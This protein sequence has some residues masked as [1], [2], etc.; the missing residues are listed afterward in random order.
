MLHSVRSK[1]LNING[2]GLLDA[3][4]IL[5]VTSIAALATLSLSNQT[6]KNLKTFKEK[7]E[8]QSYYDQM[9]AILG[10]TNL[11]T[12]A[13]YQKP[14]NP[15]QS[16]G[17]P[18]P[19][20]IA[21][22][23]TYRVTTPQLTPSGT[24]YQLVP[25]VG[26]VWGNFNVTQVELKAIPGVTNTAN[27][28]HN[29]FVDL[30][31]QLTPNTKLGNGN[32]VFKTFKM[33]ITLDSA[34]RISRCTLSVADAAVC[35]AVDGVWNGTTQTCATGQTRCQELG[36]TWDA[37]KNNCDLGAKGQ[38]QSYGGTWVDSTSGNRLPNTGA[39]T[40]QSCIISPAG[41]CNRLGGT[42]N[43]NTGGCRMNPNGA[44]TSLGGAWQGNY[45]RFAEKQVCETFGGSWEDGARRCNF[46]HGALC[47][48]LYGNANYDCNVDVANYCTSM[49]GLWSQNTC[50]GLTAETLCNKTGGA[51][52]KGVCVTDVQ[53]ACQRLGGT[54]IGGTCKMNNEAT[55][56]AGNLS[57]TIFSKLRYRDGEWKGNDCV[58]TF[59]EARDPLCWDGF[60]YYVNGWVECR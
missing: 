32:P 49:G 51:W 48:K 6:E 17:Q 46:S 44:C 16:A 19:Q 29:T 2:S 1:L 40:G 38:C 53:D 41:M 12:S 3:M 14:F 26:S 33:N 59:K 28:P 15:G 13:F 25:A 27:G 10:D 39:Y 18:L 45:C 56:T 5:G 37:L 7:S 31:L 21:V 30:N 60:P 42:W 35:A 55:C 34:N 54:F 11:C 57:T 52:V 22:Y 50:N 43:S 20:G 4:M 58:Y 36:G 24:L 8:A 9:S 47:S 23:V